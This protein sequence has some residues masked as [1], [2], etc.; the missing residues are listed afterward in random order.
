[1]LMLQYHFGPVAYMDASEQV[2]WKEAR[3]VTYSFLCASPNRSTACHMRNRLLRLSTSL[4]VMPIQ[5]FC[6][7]EASASRL[8]SIY[9][10]AKK[11]LSNVDEFSRVDPRAVFVNND[12]NLKRIEW[13]G[14]DY[15]YTLAVY[16]RD[17][18][19]LI[20]NLAIKR[21]IKDF[22]YPTILQTIPYDK[23]FAIRGLHY[24]I[25]NC[26]LLKVD[27]FS[28]IQKGTA[29]RGKRALDDAE[30]YSLYGGI[31]L[32]DDKGRG[33]PQLMDLFSLPFFGLVLTTVQYFDDHKIHFDPNS[34]YQD[35]AECVKQVHV[36]GE[37]YKSVLSNMEKYVHKNPGLSE[38]L[39]RLHKSGKHLFMITNS[40]FTFMNAGMTY[41]LGPDWRELFTHVVVQ[42]RKPDFFQG[43]TPFRLFNETTGNL[44]YEK[45]Q[46]LEPGKVY[47]GGN[48]GEFASKASLTGK[49]VLYF[50]DHIYTDLADPMLRLGWHTAAIV[51]ELAREI[52]AQN[53]DEYRRSI[54]WL[55]TLTNLIANFQVDG[56]RNAEC[57]QI[58][59]EWAEERR[60]LRENVKAIF[61]PRFGS[62]F[63]TYHNMTF[64][65]RRLMR[66]SDFYTSRLPNLLKYDVDHSFFPR[67][68]AL[69]HESLNA[70]PTVSENMIDEINRKHSSQVG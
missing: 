7:R 2:W 18:N 9:E 40:P 4:A 3:N 70:V 5:R 26:V 25:Q 39:Q 37:M 28:Q 45:V 22:H 11:S 58:I 34:L 47:A 30:I 24:D 1:M 50:G 35:I 27:A 15:D 61:N 44:H 19:E 68:N 13:Y 56:R 16:T 31:T 29:Y 20:Y 21:L 55:E 33:L 32:P 8:R 54:Q 41:M 66:L 69:P 51:P 53:T 14:F 67:R 65:S 64:F 36:T 46:E 52:R 23:E 10:F 49:G 43:K 12:L 57:G 63:R 59:N 62:M 38:Y 60:K 42:A 17:L 6:S 48:I